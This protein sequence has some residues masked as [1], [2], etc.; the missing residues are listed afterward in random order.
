MAFRLAPLIPT[1]K[2]SN[3]PTPLAYG[4]FSGFPWRVGAHCAP[5]EELT[6]ARMAAL[7]GAGSLA[8]AVT[9]CAS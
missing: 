2:H 8:Q 7:S 5:S 9:T 3:D 1:G 6:M 4:F